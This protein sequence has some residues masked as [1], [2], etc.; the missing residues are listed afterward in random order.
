MRDLVLLQIGVVAV[1]LAFGALALLEPDAIPSIPVA[2]R[3]LVWWIVGA[4]ALIYGVLALRALR[5]FQLT[6]RLGDLAV[7][8]GLVWL[9]HRGR[10]VPAQP[11]LVGRL[12]ERARARA[13]RIPR[14]HGRARERS[15]ARHAL[16]RAALARSTSATS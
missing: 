13:G 12:L 10:D 15:R 8:A 4:N 6:R 1:V 16:A 3:P 7:A 11:G 2:L 5:T 9:A 14:R